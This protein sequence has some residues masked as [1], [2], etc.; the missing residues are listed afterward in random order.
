MTDAT[1]E[2]PEPPPWPH[3]T[4]PTEARRAAD[5]RI[6]FRIHIALDLWNAISEQRWYVIDTPN[7]QFTVTL[8]SDEDVADWTPV[9]LD[10]EPR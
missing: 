2:L 6:A 3:P 10:V 1:R 5:G 9:L 4:N 7:G 8:L